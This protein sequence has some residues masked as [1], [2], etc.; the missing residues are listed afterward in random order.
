M[1]I[2]ILIL[3]IFQ[4]QNML[5]YHVNLPMSVNPYKDTLVDIFQVSKIFFIT[6]AIP[7]NI[8]EI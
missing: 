3:D 6:R 5:C 4:T 8:F 1:F 7:N 2:T